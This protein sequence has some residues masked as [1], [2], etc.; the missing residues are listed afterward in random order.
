MLFKV[1]EV[2]CTETFMLKVYHTPAQDF[3]LG[4][5]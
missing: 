1:I 4:S 5:L 2:P 3:D